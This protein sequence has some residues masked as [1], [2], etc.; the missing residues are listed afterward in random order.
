MMPSVSERN[1]NPNSTAKGSVS[2]TT[3]MAGVSVGANIVVCG[4][5]AAVV[6]VHVKSNG[7]GVPVE[8]V[9][10]GATGPPLSV[11]VYVCRG[12]SNPFGTSATTPLAEHRTT[13]PTGLLAASCSRTV[14]EFTLAGSS[15]LE[16]TALGAT[17]VGISVAPGGGVT[18]RTCSGGG[19]VV[20]V[21][22]TSAARAMPAA[23]FTRG[24][25][26][27]PLTNAVYVTPV[28]RDAVGSSVAVNVAAS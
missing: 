8:S 10:W 23:S 21:Q 20:K 1:F 22:V 28:D 27:P 5:A 16:N 11:T 25:A 3:G 7:S 17:P 24:S 18:E 19:V 15:G 12:C 14:E 9:M 13:A 2:L 26:L 4:A 6:N